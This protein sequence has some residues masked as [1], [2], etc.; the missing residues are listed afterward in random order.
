MNS[1]CWRVSALLAL[2]TLAVPAEAQEKFNPVPSAI[3]SPDAATV[4]QR[5]SE[6]SE[7]KTP[8]PKNFTP[9]WIASLG[10]RGEARVYTRDNSK[11]FAYLGMPIGGIGAGELYLS[12]DGKVWLWDIFNTRTWDGFG[13][14]QGGAFKV[15]HEPGKQDNFADVLDQGFVLQTTSDGKTTSRTI[16]KD[17]FADVKFRGQYPIGY[18]DYSDPG[19]PVKVGLEA[20]SPFVPGNVADSSYPA[21]LLN[22]TLTNTSDKP[23][24]CVIG[25]WVENGA[26]WRARK[27]TKLK[28]ENAVVTTPN[29]AAVNL[30][31]QQVMDGVRPPVVFEDFES[32]TYDKDKWTVEGTAF[33]TGPVKVGS[34]KR[35][36]ESPPD[37]QGQYYVD[38]YLNDSNDAQGKLTSKPFVID[39]PYIRFLVGGG[40]LQSGQEVNLLVNHAP[41][42]ATAGRGTRHLRPFFWDVHDLMGKTAQLQV[43]DGSSGG[44][45]F[46]QADDFRFADTARDLSEE[47]DTGSMTLALLDD[48]SATECVANANPSLAAGGKVEKTSDTILS[49]PAGDS[50]ESA[51]SDTHPTPHGAGPNLATTEKGTLF[52]DNNPRLIGGLRHKVTLQ[53]GQKVTLHYVLSWYFPNPTGMPTE[54]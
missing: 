39:H 33:G 52:Q 31:A 17:G 35:S 15:P 34:V 9:E 32:G 50:A 54:P 6:G 11:N 42:R 23:V 37:C 46:I 8:T 10:K 14:E 40:G 12:G 3:E 48:P 25:G 4:Q 53:P 47:A 24:D 30:S 13:I 18:V 41:V 44:W 45:S 36:I 1:S 7:G 27:D 51:E 5:L 38:T 19:C 2:V 29:Y 43:V 22:Y 16:D 28:L 49:A 20:F 21:T 26:S